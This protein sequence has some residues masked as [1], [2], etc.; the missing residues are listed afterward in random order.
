MKIH[1]ILILLLLSLQFRL[2][3]QKKGCTDPGA[4]NFDTAAKMNDGS[5]QYNPAQATLKTVCSRLADEITETSG[6]IYFG[7]NFWTINDSG[8][9]A[10]LYMFD[11]L[12]GKILHRTYIS[13]QINNDWEELTQDETHIYIG[14]FGNNRGSRTDL[15]ILKIAKKDMNLNGESDTVT[16]EVIRF[17]MKDQTNFNNTGQNHDYDMEAFCVMGDSLHLFSKNWVDGK[18]RHY[19]CPAQPGNW[20]LLPAETLD[21]NGQIT[22]ACYRNGVV[23]L[24]GYNKGGMGSF[25]YLMWDFRNYRLMNGNRRRIDCGNALIPGQNE[26]VCFNGNTMYMSSEK[27]ISNAALYRL[28]TGHWT[29]IPVHTGK[30]QQNIRIR[31]QSG[32]MYLTHDGT[33]NGKNI[34]MY[35]F[36]GRLVRTYTVHGVEEVYELSGLSQGKYIISTGNDLLAE[37]ML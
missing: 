2:S 19:V 25:L 13:N 37:V 4:N 22:G 36:A 17:V 35:D 30:V 1:N 8:N 11:S 16:A 6:L 34:Q 21:V 27:Q 33:L 24:T 28:Y 15:N 12:T 26:A 5:C 9:P 7:G 14:D 3:G 18:S 20:E 29:S 32:K 23:I 31:T 10:I